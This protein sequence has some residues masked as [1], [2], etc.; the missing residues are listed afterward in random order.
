MS[1][2]LGPEEVQDVPETSHAS[3]HQ[4]AQRLPWTWMECGN[5]YEDTVS[6]PYREQGW[7]WNIACQMQ[8]PFVITEKR[9]SKETG[10]FL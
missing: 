10:L 6:A 2:R 9:K 7:Q 5:Q 8:N 4:N 1:K 3:Q